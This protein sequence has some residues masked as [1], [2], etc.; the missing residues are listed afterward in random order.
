MCFL[1]FSFFKLWK[2]TNDVRKIATGESKD[3]RY[4]IAKAIVRQ[5]PNLPDILFDAMFEECYDALRVNNSLYYVDEIVEEYQKWYSKLEI[6][7]PEE[8]KG[9]H[10]R[11][12]HSMYF[13]NK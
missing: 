13:S 12:F 1:L 3:C 8:F 11:K 10:C 2:M 4:A 9:M 7:F 6:P 5:D